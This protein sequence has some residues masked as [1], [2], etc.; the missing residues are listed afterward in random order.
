[1]LSEPDG[2]QT[3]VTGAVTVLPGVLGKQFFYLQIGQAAIQVFKNDAAFPVLKVGQVVH[4]KG[5]LSTSGTERRLKITSTGTIEVA[6]EGMIPEPTTKTISELTPELNGTLLKIS[7]TLSHV[8]ADELELEKD[9]AKLTVGIGQ[10]TNIDT[11]A[12]TAGM[13]L[14]VT[15]ILRTFSGGLK[16]MPRSQA[17]VVIEE[18]AEPTPLAATTDSGKSQGD[19]TQ[20]RTALFLAISSAVALAAWLVRQHLLNK[21]NDYDAHTLALGTEKAR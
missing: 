10:Y 17:D 21:R 8:T 5:E 1:V 6:T 15:G 16:L 14:Q 19:K 13:K 7:G 4:V 12:L 3:E 2:T 18:V 20:Q 11:S 9:G